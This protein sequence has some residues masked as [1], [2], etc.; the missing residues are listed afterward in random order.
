MRFY[1]AK[2]DIE[3]ENKRLRRE[4]EY[5]RHRLM[6][7]GEKLSEK[8]SS[9]AVRFGDVSRMAAVSHKRTYVGYLVGRFKASLVFRLWD[10]TRFA[11][12]G[13]FLATK[14]WNFLVWF[15]ILLGFGTQFVLFVSVAAVLLPALLLVSAVLGIF[16][17]FA[18]RK[19][20]MALA[21]FLTEQHDQRLYILFA[22]KA[23][24]SHAYF[25]QMTMDYA[26][27]ATVFLIFT[28]FSACGYRGAKWLS[29]SVCAVHI[30][31]YFSLKKY[32]HGDVVQIYG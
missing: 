24:E 10:R 16:G 4:N 26:E 20:N 31:Y 22:P 21:E 5:L 14:I 6:A 27:N 9:F 17:F 15:F 13:V 25:Y 2:R 18:H 30:S 12:R 28:S 8:D 23:W 3:A 29:P 7:L 1:M 19:W 32:L 11:V